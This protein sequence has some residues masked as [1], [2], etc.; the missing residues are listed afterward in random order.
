M[1]RKVTVKAS[2][3]ARMR[4]AVAPLK[5]FPV[6]AATSADMLEAFEDKLAEFGIESSTQ[7]EASTES[8]QRAV[9]IY[10]EDWNEKYEDLEGAFGGDRGDIY[11][12]GEIKEYWNKENMSDPV[13]AEY[14]DWDSWWRDTRDNFLSEYYGE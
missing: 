3:E 4:N 9:E 12:L 2:K 1:K 11:S 13:L 8:E 14:S 7:V 5:G 6:K 10:G